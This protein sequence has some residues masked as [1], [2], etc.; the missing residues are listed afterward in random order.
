MK[1]LFLII[2]LLATT[3]TQSI[4]AAD[5]PV[6]DPAAV[7]TSGRARFTVLTNRMIRIQYSA[8]SRQ[9]QATRAA[10]HHPR[11]RWLSLH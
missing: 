3:A 8:T 11:G 7:V 9:P 1:K 2:I 10:V 5:D 4:L 6:A